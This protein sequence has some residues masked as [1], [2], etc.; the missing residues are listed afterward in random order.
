MAVKAMGV[1]LDAALGWFNSNVSDDCPMWSLWSGKDLL[2][3]YNQVDA[4]QSLEHF[5]TNVG[6]LVSQSFNDLV[7]IR[8]HFLKPNERNDFIVLSLKTPITS[9]YYFR[10]VQLVN[11][12]FDTTNSEYY[13]TTGEET[14][15]N[16]LARLE[17]KLFRK[18][19]EEEE[20][21]EETV[22]KAEI[23]NINRPNDIYSV[24]TKII[25][26]PAIQ[27]A[28]IGKIMNWLTPKQLTSSR[29]GDTNY[30]INGIAAQNVN[31][32]NE[33]ELQTL[34]ENINVLKS[35]RPQILED[36]KTLAEIA[37]TNPMKAN[38]ILGMLPK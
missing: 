27:E 4:E 1:G 10:P 35:I 25:E 38:I 32:M 6:L 14:Y 22:N 12:F 37:A 23:G 16:R 3:S 30:N 20:E 24:L 36:L 15:G 18:F 11:K 28:V 13:K 29:L 26:I 33:V 21:E 5:E 34:V 2:F 17:D 8:S 9:T 7:T 31:F 19:E